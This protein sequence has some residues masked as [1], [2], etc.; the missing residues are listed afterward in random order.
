[1]AFRRKRKT[2]AWLDADVG[3]LLIN[4]NQLEEY[5]VSMEGPEL[6]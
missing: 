2:F 3:L 5:Y 1:V 6:C 4:A